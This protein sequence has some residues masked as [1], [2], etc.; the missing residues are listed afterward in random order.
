M[1][2]GGFAFYSPAL[3]RIFRW[4]LYLSAGGLLLG[5]VGVSRTNP[6]RWHAPACSIGMI[7][8]WLASAAME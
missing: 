5:L 6:L 3:L 8:F 4:G 7:L 2:T 1:R